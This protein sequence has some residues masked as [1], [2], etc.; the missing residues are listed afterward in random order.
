MKDAL[1]LARQLIAI[2]SITGNER[3]A[4]EWVAAQLEMSGWPVERQPVAPGRFNIR[5][6][7]R[8]STLT[9]STHLDTVPPFLTP[10][11]DAEYLR[12]RGACDTKGV[13]AA[14]MVAA[15]RLR[16]RHPDR[17]GLLFVVGEERDSAGARVANQVPNQSRYLIN[18]EPTENKLA[19]GTKGSLRV[20]VVAAGRSAHSAYPHLGESAIL[21][22]LD[23]LQR[24]RELELDAN[25]VLGPSTLNIGT[26]QAGTRPNIV[27]DHAEAELMF[28]TVG[29]TTPLKQQVMAVAGT[30]LELEWR[31]EVP[32]LR[33]KTVQGFEATVVAYT[34]DIPFL[35]NWGEP[36]LVGPG[37]IHDAHTADEKISK[38]QLLEAVELYFEL[39][40]RLLN[41]TSSEP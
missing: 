30:E 6:G 33:L 12:G 22:L 40:N 41:G 26:L 39:G 5:A 3:T 25:P 11:E 17:I 23:F 37:S 2:E 14:M 7:S 8:K 32:P 38:R 20:N 27:P 9:F 24:L 15:D 34:T 18:G 1:D 36:L 10:G 19:L 31:F 4:G 21:K 16:S 28:R 35:T 29:D 13:L